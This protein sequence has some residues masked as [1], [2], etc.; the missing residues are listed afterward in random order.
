M[1]T[2]SNKEFQSSNQSNL[3]NS[4][5]SKFKSTHL[6]NYIV[7]PLVARGE[8]GSGYRNKRGGCVAESKRGLECAVL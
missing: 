3:R 4:R 7:L 6:R 5:S 2:Q 1:D 8:E